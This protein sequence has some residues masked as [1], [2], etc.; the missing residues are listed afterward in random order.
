MR[1]DYWLAGLCLGRAMSQSVTMVYSAAIPVLMKV[2]EMSAARAG[3]IS[4]GYQIGYAVS[5]LIISTL[6]D[7]IGARSSVAEL[8]S[9]R[10]L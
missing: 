8:K 9:G 6:A 5:L 3:T 4:S 10:Y 7:R 1:I 2:W